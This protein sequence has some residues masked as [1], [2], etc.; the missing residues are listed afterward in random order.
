M[1]KIS[2]L[3]DPLD[4]L[5][6][7]ARA[8]Q[9]CAMATVTSTWGSSP[10]P[11]GSMMAVCANGRIEGSVSG[12]CVEGAVIEEARTVMDTGR[13]VA[14]SYGVS[15]DEAWAVG[16]ACGGLLDV[17]V[18][19]IRTPGHPQ[20][21]LDLE[22]LETVAAKRHA[23]VPVIMATEL[24]TGR[25]RLLYRDAAPPGPQPD[26][27]LETKLHARAAEVFA[28]GRSLR[29][30]DDTGQA[31]WFLHLVPMQ[32]RLLV[33]GAVH[34]A[35]VLAPMAQTTG[36]DVTVVDPRTQLATAERFP[37]ITLHTDWPDEAMAQMGV[38]NQTAI[39]T[40]THDAKLDDP[41]LHYAL[42]SDAFYIGALGSRK[43]QASRVKR[44]GD[45]G[46]TPAQIARIHG[47]VGLAIG[48]VGAAEIALSIL[49]EIV[50][51][52]HDRPLG[53]V[54]GWA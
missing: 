12:G 16:L 29:L 31:L 39:V 10:R 45:A 51:V 3:Q 11:A 41:T 48:A 6:D 25:T 17:Y 43:T 20:G 22:L 32:P 19:A 13:P 47:P 49:A 28:T 15:S 5:I 33:V 38:D 35:Q 54:S 53:R 27:G 4:L 52:R 37:G 36:F 21:T 14:L 23:R 26:N 50:A 40:L 44:L 8:G 1:T 34:I 9:P 18:T 2:S 24:A 7:W 30:E 42:G 46:F